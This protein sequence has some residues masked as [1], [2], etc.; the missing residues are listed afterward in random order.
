MKM[1]FQLGIAVL[2]GIA[3]PQLARAVAP[4][5]GEMTEA[6]RWAAAKFGGVSDAKPLEADRQAYDVEPL[7]SFIYDSKPSAELL[8]TWICKRSSQKLDD[9]RTQH[10]IVY[11]DPNTG[12]EVRCAAVEY[13]D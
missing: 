3:L 7:F 4:T 11:F 9:K 2:L 5:A 12:L 10:A 13:A 6:R 8:K 1:N